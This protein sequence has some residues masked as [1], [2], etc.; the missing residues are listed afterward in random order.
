[1]SSCIH[2]VPTEKACPWCKTESAK[3][4]PV[5]KPHQFYQVEF[6]SFLNT[7]ADESR[8]PLALVVVAEDANG[9]SYVHTAGPIEHQIVLAESLVAHLKQKLNTKD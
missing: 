4:F 2:H 5:K 3:G 6:A 8:G 7:I 1:M 9:E